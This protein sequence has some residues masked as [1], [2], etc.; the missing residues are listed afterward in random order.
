MPAQAVTASA[1]YAVDR[2][3]LRVA[4]LCGVVL[5]LEG[6]DIAAVVYAVPSLVEAWRVAPSVF[7]Q[8]LAA[9]NVGMLLG[10]L[11]AGLLGDRL[12]R[13]PM[14][15]GCVAVLG[16]FSLLAALA[17][18]PLQLAGVRF[19]TGLGLGGGI[20]LAIALASDF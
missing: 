10:S 5:F 20:P 17:S 3:H 13:K 9:G 16:S 15:I 4:W 18:S 7:T 8:A 1:K 2:L 11:C 12:G 6:Y 19:L 14:M